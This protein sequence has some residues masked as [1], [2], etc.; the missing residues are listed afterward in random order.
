MHHKRIGIIGAG[1]A[2]LIATSELAK[3]GHEVTLFERAKY[4][5][6]TAGYYLRKGVEYPTG[7]TISFGMEPDGPLRTLLND[8]GVFLEASPADHSMDVV[9]KDRVIHVYHD[10]E[11]WYSELARAFPER[12]TEVIL[13]WKRLHE[14]ADVVY[15]VSKT[16]I[17]LPFPHPNE[18]RKLLK[19]VR[20]SPL[21]FFHLLPEIHWTVA[22]ALH[23]Y[24]LFDYA[25]FCRFLNAQLTDAAQT[26]I[27]EAAW[28]P[29]AIALDIYRYGVY[30]V[31]GGFSAISQSLKQRA[32]D[33]GAE[34]LFSTTVERAMYEEKSDRWTLFTN[35]RE[36]YDFDVIINA[37][38][39]SIKGTAKTVNSNSLEANQWG[40]VRIDALV[41]SSWVNQLGLSVDT[42]N[43]P[44]AFQIATD[45]EI[46]ELL[47]DPHGAV[48][49]TIHPTD[50]D[51]QV[52]SVSVHTPASDWLYLMPKDYQ[53]KKEVATI[54][55][56]NRVERI[57][58]G[59]QQHAVVMRTGTP[60]TY[61]KYLLKQAV[62][63]TPL[64]VYHSIFH[65]TRVKTRLPGW[66]IA[67]DSAFP[68]PGVMSAAISGFY[69]ARAIDP[70]ISIE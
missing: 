64:T 29:G 35:H 59:F 45:A 40:A 43:N 50:S 6:G 7:A 4:P 21:A 63:G 48:Y 16:L 13:F 5:G 8:A 46:G 1:M 62:G 39:T 31:P 32:S 11:R 25:P 34:L 26:D 61:Q 57:L 65:P 10:A 60:A 42:G 38:G 55:M 3:Q 36:T 51:Q 66:F 44:F 33:F 49:V 18:G 28:L 41:P 52:I 20:Q 12:A 47:H 54:A 22:D 70:G 15:R 14:V 30:S 27:T 19:V 23:K 9:L 69:A 58:P 24:G 17:S 67:G 37:S 2:G 53:L 56:I 68:G